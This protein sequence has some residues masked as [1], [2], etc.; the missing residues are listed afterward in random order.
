MVK[1]YDRLIFV[2]VDDTCRA[3]M[4]KMIMKSK[5]LFS[6]LEIDSRGLVVLFPE[7]INQKA[8]AVLISNGFHAKDHKAVQFSQEDVGERVLILTMEESQRAKILGNYEHVSDIY[9]IAQYA[10]E[11]ED[12][13]PLYGAPLSAYGKCYETLETLVSGVVIRL[14]EEELKR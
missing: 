1:E 12:V 9:T 4:A 11:T 3:P 7:P 2:D 5:F 6:P 10:G 14:N 13:K 8:E